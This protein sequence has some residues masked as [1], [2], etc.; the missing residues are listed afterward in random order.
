MRSLIKIE[1]PKI[2]DEW[3]YDESAKKSY[4]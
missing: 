2:L 4:G 1:F 3:D